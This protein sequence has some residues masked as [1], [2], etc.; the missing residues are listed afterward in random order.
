MKLSVYT[1]GSGS[2]VGSGVGATSS[3]VTSGVAA[4]GA[5]LSST[6]TGMFTSV[7][8]EE[9]EKSE[10]M[11]RRKPSVATAQRRASVPNNFFIYFNLAAGMSNHA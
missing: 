9:P 11:K 5:A 8:R 2:G 7:F 1:S 10:R 4:T 3:G 6:G